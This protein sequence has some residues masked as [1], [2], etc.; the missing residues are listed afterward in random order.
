MALAS[1]VSNSTL[2]GAADYTLAANPLIIRDQDIFESAS[3]LFEQADLL[4]LDAAPSRY[5]MET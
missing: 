1:E 2:T 3:K 4:T 5:V